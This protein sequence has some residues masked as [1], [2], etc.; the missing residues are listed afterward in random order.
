M[1]K[2]NARER[3]RLTS[4]CRVTPVITPTE[5][6][7]LGKNGQARFPSPNNWK[8][9]NYLFGCLAAA[10]ARSLA[11]SSFEFFCRSENAT[12]W[13]FTKTFTAVATLSPANVPLVIKVIIISR[14]SGETHTR[15]CAY[16]RARANR[17]INYR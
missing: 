11:H 13:P 1:C 8:K 7:P 15:V 2:M 12:L 6:I 16:T 3:G 14:V 4:T 9:R 17:D 5:L 10:H